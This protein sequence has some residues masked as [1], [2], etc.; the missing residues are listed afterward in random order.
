MYRPLNVSSSSKEEKFYVLPEPYNPIIYNAKI[1][2]MLKFSK[3]S[4]FQ[5]FVIGFRYQPGVVYSH[6]QCQTC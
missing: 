5:P 6:I 4:Y 2:Q 3:F 1:T